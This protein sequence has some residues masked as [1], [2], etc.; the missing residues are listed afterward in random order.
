MVY[1]AVP[2]EVALVA[3]TIDEKSSNAPVPKVEQ[4]IYVKQKPGW[5]DISIEEGAKV[6]DGPTDLLREWLEA[7]EK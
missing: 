1:N 2:D 6:Y 4:H 7:A 5:Y 3:T